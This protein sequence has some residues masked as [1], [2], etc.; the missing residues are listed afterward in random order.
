MD[1][2]TSESN[3]FG[4]AVRQLSRLFFS[5]ADESKRDRGTLAGLR[6]GL[7][8]PRGWHPAVAMVVDRAIGDVHL[9]DSQRDVLNMTA[10]LFSIHPNIRKREDRWGTSLLD[11]LSQLQVSLGRTS[12]EDR[13]A[14]DRRVMALLNADQEDVFHHLRHLIRLFRNADVAIDWIQLAY[15]LDSWSSTERSVQRRWARQ[16]WGAPGWVSWQEAPAS[17]ATAGAETE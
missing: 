9:R 17:P 7:G 14:L 3:P 13:Q 2:Q 5:L 15:D 11:S 8:E 4:E 10:A 1:Q 6:K 16:W 12:D